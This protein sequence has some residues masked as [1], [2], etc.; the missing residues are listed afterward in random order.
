M[1]DNPFRPLAG[2]KAAPPATRREATQINTEWTV[3][4]PV[5]KNAP[6]APAEHFKRG[7][8]T[9]V[10]SYRDARGDL[11]GHVCRFDLADGGKEFFP[12]TYCR[13][14]KGELA[15]RW[16]SWAAPRPLYNLDWLAKKPKRP[17]IVCEGEKAAD[18]AAKLFPDHVVVTSPHG[19]QSAT[20]AD[21][22]PLYRR[23]VTIWPDADEPGRKYA[24]TVARLLAP[25]AGSIKRLDP[26]KDVKPGW[27][28]A[29]AIDE[30][31]DPS[32]AATFIATAAS[33]GPRR[34]RRREE[35]DAGDHAAG[36]AA[37]AGSAD[38]PETGPR[39]RQADELLDLIAQI[40]LW[41]S[42]DREPYATV[43]VNGHFENWPVRS[44]GFR[45]WL[46]EQYFRHTARGA[47]SQATEDAMRTIEAMA[48]ANG[49]EHTPYLRIGT[50]GDDIYLDL[51]D[52]PWRAVRISGI[53][54]WNVV[55]C[56]P[57]KFLRTPAMAP[58][59]EPEAGGSIDELRAFMQLAA[60]QP[61]AD[62]LAADHAADAFMLAVAW[63]VGTFNPSGPY[64]V[65]AIYGGSG[66]GKTS[67][68]RLLRSMIDPSLA[69]DRAPPRD[70][71]A[72]CL[73]GK[74]S[75]VLALDNLS[76]IPGWLSDAMCRLSTGGG[77]SARLLYSNDEE[78]LYFLKRPQ[79][80]TAIPEAAQR[81]DLVSRSIALTLPPLP[82]FNRR[83][84]AE[85][86]AEVDKVRP[87]VLGSLLDGVA[88]ALRRRH[89]IP[90]RQLPRM[91]DFATWIW[92]ACPGLGWEPNAFLDAYDTNQ[93]EGAD[94]VFEADGLG[95][96][97]AGL[98]ALRPAD[99]DGCRRWIGTATKLLD[100]L[101]VD[102]KGRKSRW[103]PPSN[104]VRGRLRRL[105]GVLE[106]RGI[107][108]DLETR[109]PGHGRDR[110]ITIT[111]H[112]PADAG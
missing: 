109:A 96:A 71:S 93:A 94:I 46:A 21:W 70:E 1:A 3:L 11:I 4:A 105:Q 98:L 25:I 58:L 100:D 50:H 12:L 90:P 79:V 13:S 27:D 64:P 40:E 45:L 14:A 18:A 42:P 89:D 107:I 10:Y 102:E 95:A 23:E 59:P 57:C 76:S 7:K 30:G 84:E 49:A 37:G 61:A 83:T 65:L 104:Q 20:K 106:T 35:A 52:A 82:K 5:P 15:W 62:P 54:G 56:A 33:F 92:R 29:D 87:L 31:W 16:Q 22:A 67:L 9:A 103:W 39:R 48:I 73:A 38:A 74:N 8:P 75:W 77:I 24:E 60:D 19:S 47:S 55:D 91:A 101:P 88:S 86:A 66:S 41:H 72:L 32:R 108:L 78:V 85:F 6:A 97:V 2:G 110:L 80:F 26:P 112:P 36:E 44:K 43:P 63:L 68:A 69:P 51:C 111:A 53:E 28:A 34:R 99:D 81:G 17:V